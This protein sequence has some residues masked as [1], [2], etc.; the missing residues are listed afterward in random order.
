MSDDHRHTYFREKCM[1]TKTKAE[2]FIQFRPALSPEDPKAR[3]PGFRQR[4][5]A[6][7]AGQQ[8]Q[9][10]AKALPV[11]LVMH[12]SQ[13]MV[14]SDGTTPFYDIFLPSG[15]EDL[16]ALVNENEKIPAL[17]ACRSGWEV[18]QEEPSQ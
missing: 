17:V 2:T 16:E 6:F 8:I 3:F 1:D 18:Q 9:K 10:G 7:K 12:E 11:D 13:S 15:F 5:N 14:L 4:V